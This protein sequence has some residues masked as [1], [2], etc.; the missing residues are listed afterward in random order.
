M[1]LTSEHCN[2]LNKRLGYTKDHVSAGD[3][4]GDTVF[5]ILNRIIDLIEKQDQGRMVR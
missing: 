1:M 5:N 2:Q 3:E 4:V